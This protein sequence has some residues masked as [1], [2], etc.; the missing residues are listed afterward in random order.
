MRPSSVASRKGMANGSLEQV[1]RSLPEDTPYG[2][3]RDAEDLAGGPRK[4]SRRFPHVS[5][6]LVD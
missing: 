3:S 2:R 1:G 6:G 5:F 4:R